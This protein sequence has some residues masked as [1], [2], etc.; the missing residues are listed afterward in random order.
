MSYGVGHRRSQIWHCCGWAALVLPLAQEIPY[1][2]DVALKKKKKKKKK[3]ENGNHISPSTYPPKK[4]LNKVNV[5]KRRKEGREEGR[6]GIQVGKDEVKLGYLQMTWYHLI[7]NH[8][9]STK[10]FLELVNK[11]NK[12]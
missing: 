9:D 11:S 2:A 8:K 4:N 7:E 10:K 1:V 6:A 12:V 5:K 3:E